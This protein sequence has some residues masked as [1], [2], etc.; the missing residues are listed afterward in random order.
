MAHVDPGVGQ[1]LVYHAGVELAGSRRLVGDEDVKAGAF[2]PLQVREPERLHRDVVQGHVQQPSAEAVDPV[3]HGLPT[4]ELV[5]HQGGT[6][7][8][9]QLGPGELVG[10]VVVDV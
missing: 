9:Q 5:E 3:P 6:L 8:L 2:N 1:D 10:Q 7:A 4:S